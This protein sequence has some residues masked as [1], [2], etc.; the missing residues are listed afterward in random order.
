[1]NGGR[2]GLS[3]DIESKNVP[4]QANGEKS[5]SSPSNG[6]KS[7]SSP[8]EEKKDVLEKKDE[9][10]AMISKNEKSETKSD[11]PKV[12]ED[13]KVTLTE[14]Q[15]DEEKIETCIK[16]DQNGTSE[17]KSVKNISVNDNKI[18]KQTDLDPSTLT[19]SDES[20]LEPVVVIDSKKK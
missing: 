20:K 19:K 18:E 5:P 13:M 6:Q 1:M 8:M 16:D 3:L 17:D 9:D 11:S 7:A 15:V 10:A 2:N 14:D 4:S 12:T